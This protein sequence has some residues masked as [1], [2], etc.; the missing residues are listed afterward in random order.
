MY[1]KEEASKLKQSFWTTFGQ[2]MASVP[3]SEGMKIN[4]INYKTGFKH[5]YFKMDAGKKEAYIAIE[6]NHPDMG[7]QELFF[8][9]FKEFKKILE[10]YLNETWSWKLH[11][12]DEHG[13]IISRIYCQIDPVSVFNQ[14]DWPTLISFFKP[15]IIALDEFW[16]MVKDS[17]EALK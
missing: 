5:L 13:K 15:R 7:I 14:A 8:E 12:E 4:W 2:Y 17:F 1:S 9:Q 3:S 10:G 16:N 6:I 11:T